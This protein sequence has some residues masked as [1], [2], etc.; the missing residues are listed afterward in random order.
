MGVFK[1]GRV[2]LQDEHG[3]G[4]PPPEYL[5]PTARRETVKEVRG[6]WVDVQHGEW[7]VLPHDAWHGVE[8]LSSGYR[9]SV[10]YFVP[11]GLH[12]VTSEQ[13]RELI[14][15]GFPC[16]QLEAKHS[17]TL[18]R[19]T[20][21]LSMMCTQDHDVQTQLLNLA[22][23]AGFY[24]RSSSMYGMDCLWTEIPKEAERR[25]EA[26]L[27]T[28]HR[29]GFTV[30]KLSL[31]EAAE[32]L[33]DIGELGQ[34]SE[35]SVFVLT[36]ADG[37]CFPFRE[38][39]DCVSTLP[40]KV[41][42]TLARKGESSEQIL[43]PVGTPWCFPHMSEELE[44]EEAAEEAEL[45]TADDTEQEYHP[46]QTEKNATQLAHIATQQLRTPWTTDLCEIDASSWCREMVNPITQERELWFHIVDWGTGFQLSEHVQSKEPT[47]VFSTYARLWVKFFG[48]PSTLV[49]DG[50]LEFAADFAHAAGQYGTLLHVIDPATPW[51]NAR[52]ERSH[53]EIRKQVALTCD[54][55]MPCTDD[56]YMAA[57]EQFGQP[58]WLQCYAA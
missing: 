3:N 54:M 5:I 41:K 28:L 9:I 31:E 50:G 44:S 47:H 13:W 23:H 33:A 4:R 53:F 14:N 45:A 25:F 2:W 15:L 24:L 55:C 35:S 8:P 38:D 20:S 12:R 48:H 37:T 52:T 30:H 27:H 49:V 39:Q 56:E 42:Q 26:S 19:L 22:D 21:R 46:T 17:C 11:A 16:E 10:V 43:V 32:C 7:Y 40:R 6:R 58:Q 36:S 51:L 34:E 18:A 57:V 29:N 1:G